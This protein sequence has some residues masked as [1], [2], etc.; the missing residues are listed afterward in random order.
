MLHSQSG[1]HYSRSV[2]N[3]SFS[4]KLKDSRYQNVCIA[5]Q[6]NV[7]GTYREVQMNF[8]ISP[9]NQ[10]QCIVFYNPNQVEYLINGMEWSK[11]ESPRER[12]NHVFFST[13]NKSFDKIATENIIENEQYQSVKSM[14]MEISAILGVS[15]SS[16]SQIFGVSRPTIYSW[17]QDEEVRIHSKHQEII[18][19]VYNRVRLWSKYCE[20]PPA[21]LATNRKVEGK[22]LIEW[23]INVSITTDKLEEIMIH[24]AQRVNK[25]NTSSTPTSTLRPDGY[26]GDLLDR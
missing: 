7:G 16:L 24:L 1:F 17:I 21:L 13:P 10:T 4:Q 25:I 8:H 3:N 26:G 15:K 9:H 18:K 20:F 6:D 11:A 19:L 14:I 22:T 23:I 5:N 2:G 12:T